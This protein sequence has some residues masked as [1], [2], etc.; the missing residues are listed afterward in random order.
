METWYIIKGVVTDTEAY[1]PAYGPVPELGDTEW[2]FSDGDEF[3]RGMSNDFLSLEAGIYA[4]SPAI[5][6]YSK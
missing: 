5:F 2:Q 3:T 1:D 4:L 6:I